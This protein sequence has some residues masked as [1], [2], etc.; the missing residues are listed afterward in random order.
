M[1][2]FSVPGTGGESMSMPRL[3]REVRLS[4]SIDFLLDFSSGAIWRNL[5]KDPSILFVKLRGPA[6]AW[7]SA[8]RPRIALKTDD[9]APILNRAPPPESL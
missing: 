7:S 9:P 2:R 1:V 5:S 3:V 6:A 8:A 4:E